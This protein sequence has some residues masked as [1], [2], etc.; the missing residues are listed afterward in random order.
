M[1][2]LETL[3]ALIGEKGA[4]SYPFFP[5]WTVN[6]AQFLPLFGLRTEHFGICG[7]GPKMPSL[8]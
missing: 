3:F 4:C 8:R 1:A 6:A 7:T 5:V 2:G